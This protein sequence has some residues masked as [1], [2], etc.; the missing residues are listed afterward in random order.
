MN[1]ENKISHGRAEKLIEEYMESKEWKVI[2]D[3]RFRWEKDKCLYRPDRVFIKGQQVIL[4]EVKPGFVGWGEIQRGIGQVITALQLDGVY[5]LLLAPDKYKERL[6]VVFSRIDAD[7]GLFVFNGEGMISAI[8]WPVRVEDI[9]TPKGIEIV[10]PDLGTKQLRDIAGIINYVKQRYTTPGERK[11][12]AEALY[13][14][15]NRDN[16]E[17]WS[18]AIARIEEA[19]EEDELSWLEES[20]H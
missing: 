16:P 6:E 9:A 13:K 14:D 11:F 5:S 2:K 8:R 10:V 4:V 18:T 7:T 17:K 1:N 19:F 15:M 20:P 3:R 12:M